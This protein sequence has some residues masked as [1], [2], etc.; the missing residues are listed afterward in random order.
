MTPVQIPVHTP[1]RTPALSTTTSF[2][3]LQSR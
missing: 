2:D 3:L 1:V